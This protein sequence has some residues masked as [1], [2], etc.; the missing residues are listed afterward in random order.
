MVLFLGTI[1]RTCRHWSVVKRHFPLIVT[2]TQRKNKTKKNINKIRLH[3]RLLLRLMLQ[4]FFNLKH[5]GLDLL[6]IVHF[7]N[8]LEYKHI[9]RSICMT[10]LDV[11]SIGFVLYLYSI[12]KTN[13]R[14]YV[15]KNLSRIDL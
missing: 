4:L 2:I 7:L 13:Y 12:H 11:E 5:T 10:H 6:F 3:L 1:L 15:N 9:N 8:L 14:K